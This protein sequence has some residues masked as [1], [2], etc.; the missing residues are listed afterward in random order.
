MIAD[1]IQKVHATATPT[2]DEVNRRVYMAKGVDASYRL[3]ALNRVETIA[4]LKYQLA[5]A[6]HDVLDV[7][8]GAGRTAPYL[9][10]LA[11]RY[12]A[13][14]FSPVMVESARRRLP[15][16]SVRLADM[17]DLSAF[18]DASFDF[19][20]GANNVIDAVSHDDRLR[21][22]AEFR[23]VLRD[24]GI[25]VFS[26]HNRCYRHAGHAPR[27][28]YSRNPVTQ[29]LNV[30]RWSRQIVNYARYRGLR[31]AEPEYSLLN[32]KGHNFA[33]LHYYVEQQTQRRQLAAMGLRVVDVLDHEGRSLESS[34]PASDSP[35]LMYVARRDPEAPAV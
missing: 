24:D 10:P 18:A 35:W 1:P 14:D 33:C 20:F 25:V 28:E 8:V 27:I 32:D 21:T 31:K 29:A 5:F 15:G 16:I 9:A 7:G 6:G 30:A 2:Q 34:D 4:L 17:R 13:I 12:E 22:L 19:L 11:R 23:R 26:S 3:A